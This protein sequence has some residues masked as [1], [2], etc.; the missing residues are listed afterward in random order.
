VEEFGPASSHGIYFEGRLEER[1]W[2]L[3]AM[4]RGDWS[5]DVLSNGIPQPP[6]LLEDE[7]DAM[8]LGIPNN[9]E[10]N[11]SNFVSAASPR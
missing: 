10:E 8:A 4:S 5:E 9:S 6:Y 3:L 7:V 1:F 2:G 11:L